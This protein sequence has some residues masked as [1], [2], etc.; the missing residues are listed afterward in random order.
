ML[1]EEG[2]RGYVEGGGQHCPNPGCGRPT[3][4]VMQPDEPE[5]H[6]DGEVTVEWTCLACG[7]RFL[8]TYTLDDI[9]EVAQ[10]R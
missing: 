3:A 8:E 6:E 5:F 9:C 4:E 10:G 2:K 1:S 7:R